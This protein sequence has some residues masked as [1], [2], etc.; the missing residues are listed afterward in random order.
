MQA[1]RPRTEEEKKAN[2][3]PRVILVHFTSYQARATVYKARTKLG[4]K[5]DYKGI[6]INEFLTSEQDKLFL[7]TRKRMKKDKDP[8]QNHMCWTFNGIIYAKKGKEEP[9]RIDNMKI[10]KTN[11]KLSDN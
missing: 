7:E 8:T 2:K 11:F 6:F 5:K 4:K 10:L 3:R 1:A 9:I